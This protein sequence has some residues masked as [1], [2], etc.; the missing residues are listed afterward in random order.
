MDPRP[1]QLRAEQESLEN[2]ERAADEN[3]PGPDGPYW[4]ISSSNLATRLQA[5]WATLPP[6][7]L[8]PVAALLR[9]IIGNPFRPVTLTRTVECDRCNGKGQR[10]IGSK[11]GSCEGTGKT[12]GNAD[13]LTPTVCSL[14]Q[15]GYEERTPGRPHKKCRCGR[16]FARLQKKGL[17]PP[18]AWCNH[19]AEDGGWWADAVAREPD[20]TLV[21]LRLAVLAD[22]LE[23]AGCDNTDMM[24]HLRSPGPHVR[25]CWPI[26]LLTGKE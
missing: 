16:E 2:E 6:P 11:C 10:T 26:D 1:R 24:L 12:K 18:L 23:E 4:W 5:T 20:G 3:S 17:S 14:A 9:D 15:A 13:W 19:C 8:R 21:P 7:A 25:G 22:A